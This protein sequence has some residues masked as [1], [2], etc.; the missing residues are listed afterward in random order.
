MFEIA[1]IN[2]FLLPP[3]IL[4]IELIFLSYL[5]YQPETIIKSKTQQSNQSN[6]LFQAYKIAFSQEFDP[7]LHRIRKNE[8]TNQL[9]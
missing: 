8:S 6:N 3:I 5:L 4:I 9:V 1:S 7:K 2:Q